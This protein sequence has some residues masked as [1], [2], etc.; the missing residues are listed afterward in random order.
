MNTALQT[1]MKHAESNQDRFLS[2]SS[3]FL[4]PIQSQIRPLHEKRR[5][6]VPYDHH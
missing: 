5:H 3:Y 2:S 6:P 4:P 1:S